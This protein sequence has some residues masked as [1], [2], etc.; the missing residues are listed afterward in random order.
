M[1]KTH[2]IKGIYRGFVP[3]GICVFTRNG[4]SFI[5]MLYTQSLFSKIGLR[6]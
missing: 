6:W 3:G 4:S 2:G 5:G 1:Y